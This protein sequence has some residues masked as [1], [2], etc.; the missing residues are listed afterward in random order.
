MRLSRALIR[1]RSLHNLQVRHGLKS[2][3]PNQRVIAT[4]LAMT[5]MFNR[6]QQLFYDSK[7]VGDFISSLIVLV[8]HAADLT[9][10]APSN[11]R[12]PI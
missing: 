2:V 3:V 10:I 4:V 7:M 11:L 8:A 12:F 5:E 6:A 9:P 1:H